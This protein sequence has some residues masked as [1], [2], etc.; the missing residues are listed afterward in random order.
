M[1]ME[2]DLVTRLITEYQYVIIVP[3]VFLLGPIVSLVAGVLL[4]LDVIQPCADIPCACRRR[5][6]L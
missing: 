2:A 3:G 1:R 6:R 5:A 4:R